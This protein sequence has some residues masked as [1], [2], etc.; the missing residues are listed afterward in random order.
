MAAK[1]GRRR[2]EG[3][4]TKAAQFAFAPEML[5]HHQGEA[6]APAL[7]SPALPEGGFANSLEVAL[8]TA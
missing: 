5:P 8:P 3:A 2:P 7:P 6:T 1:K 4:A